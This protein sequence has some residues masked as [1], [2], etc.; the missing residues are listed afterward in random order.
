M[1]VLGPFQHALGR[2]D[3]SLPDSG[4]GLDID[5]DAMV[6]VDQVVDFIGLAGRGVVGACIASCRI[7]L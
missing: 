7:R 2:F 6:G 1:A 4:G 3:L 5:D